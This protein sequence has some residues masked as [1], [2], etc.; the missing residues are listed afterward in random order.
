[1]LTEGSEAMTRDEVIGAGDC[2][3]VAREFGDYSVRKCEDVLFFENV[4]AV[5][6]DE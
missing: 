1:M 2:A 3:S 5:A 6:G 4:S